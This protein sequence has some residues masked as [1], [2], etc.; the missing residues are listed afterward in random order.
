M[1]RHSSLAQ[2]RI[3]S[4][5][6]RG[7]RVP[8]LMTLVVATLGLA[9][10]VA[11]AESIAVRANGDP[12]PSG[13]VAERVP[14]KASAP[15]IVPADRPRLAPDASLPRGRELAAARRYARTRDGL[16]SFAVVD[17]QRKLHCY[18]CRMRY[19]SASLVKAML[20]VAYLDHLAAEARPLTTSD[21]FLLDA[22]IAVSDNA[23]ATAAYWRAGG[24]AA[25]HR[26]AR[27]AGMRSFDI[28]GSWETA[29]LTAADQARFFAHLQRLTPRRY[30]PYTHQLL[31][32]VVSWQSW[33]I[34]QASRPRWRTLFK[35]G[36]RGTER[37]DLVHQAARLERGSKM[38]AIAVLTDGNPSHRYGRETVRGIAARLLSSAE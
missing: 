21:R 17:S 14:S 30:W 12:P 2:P 16:V 20:L 37:G 13:Q 22:M 33:G 25:L 31:S 10:L 3:S 38:I 23:A 9:A 35:G 32:S 18:H 36:W 8:V 4:R 34:P 26:L 6:W 15:G 5:K 7:W 19:V 28:F 29:Q 11:L 1:G 27:R 24:D